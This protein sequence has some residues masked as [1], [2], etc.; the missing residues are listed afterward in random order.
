M[1]QK[2]LKKS[3]INVGIDKN[4]YLKLSHYAKKNGFV[5]GKMATNGLN[6]IIE[7]DPSLFL[8]SK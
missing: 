5:I 8:A 4:V 7:K 3:R 6:Y 1:T 2:D